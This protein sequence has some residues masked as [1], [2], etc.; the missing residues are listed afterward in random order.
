MG[1][2]PAGKG[3]RDGSAPGNIC[4]GPG[5]RRGWRGWWDVMLCSPKA[6]LTPGHCLS[7]P[8]ICRSWTL[9]QSPILPYSPMFS[10]EHP[11]SRDPTAPEGCCLPAALLSLAGGCRWEMGPTKN[12]MR[13]K[14]SQRWQCEGVCCPLSPVAIRVL[15]WP[16]APV[17]AE[18]TEPSPRSQAATASKICRAARSGL[19]DLPW[20]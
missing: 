16:L 15:P 13:L 4:T 9:H 1:S 11:R 18:F 2:I 12:G 3:W 17:S 20:G 10:Q 6:W 7:A 14:R 5:G 19:C 8:K